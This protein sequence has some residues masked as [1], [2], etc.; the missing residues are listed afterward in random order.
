MAPHQG[1]FILHPIQ[2]HTERIAPRVHIPIT[3]SEILIHPSGLTWRPSGGC[4]PVTI[5]EGSRALEKGGV[6]GL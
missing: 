2:D 5:N 1:Q 6:G 3:S 4:S